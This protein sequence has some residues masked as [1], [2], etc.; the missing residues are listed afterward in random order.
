M[1]GSVLLKGGVFRAIWICLG[2]R[3]SLKHFGWMA[4]V[5]KGWS[6]LCGTLIRNNVW[7]ETWPC[8]FGTV[9]TLSVK[10]GVCWMTFT[11]PLCMKRFELIPLL[12]K[13][14]G[15]IKWQSSELKSG[16]GRDRHFFANASYYLSLPRARSPKSRFS[17]GNVVK[18]CLFWPYNGMPGIRQA[19]PTQS[20]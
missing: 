10:C 19:V 9:V 3:V 12:F 16:T 20:C 13:P 7:A 14:G 5:C 6:C 2:T 17:C 4:G 8:L 18:L 15:R 11:K 1:W